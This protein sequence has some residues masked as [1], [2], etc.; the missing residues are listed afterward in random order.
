MKSLALELNGARSTRARAILS[1]LLAPAAFCIGAFAHHFGLA[2]EPM[3]LLIVILWI[4]IFVWVIV[5]P[6]KSASMALW[7]FAAIVGMAGTVALMFTASLWL[8]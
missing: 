1:W 3:M 8:S 5:A 6:E 7:W 4:G 2:I